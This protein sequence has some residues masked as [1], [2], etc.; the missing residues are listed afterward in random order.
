MVVSA[1]AGA[2]GSLA[3]QIAKIQGAASSASAAP[4]TRSAGCW[5]TSASTAPSTTAP[6]T[7]A[8]GSVS[9]ALI[10]STSTSTTWAAP[11]S[12]RCS[13]A[14]RCARRPLRRHR[15]LQRAGRPPGPSNY[16]QLINRRARMEGF[17]SLD[18]W[19][20][21]GEVAATLGDG[22]P[23]ASSEY[24]TQVYEGLDS[25]VDAL[26]ALFTG[27]NIGKTV[28]RRR[29]PPGRPDGPGGGPGLRRRPGG[30]GGT[31]IGRAAHPRV[32]A[33]R[34]KSV[35]GPIGPPPQRAPPLGLRRS[36]P[37]GDTRRA[38][39]AP[40]RK[41]WPRV[42]RGPATPHQDV[43]GCDRKVRTCRSSPASWRAEHVSRRRP[44]AGRCSRGRR[45]PG[46]RR[47]PSHSG[48]S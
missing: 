14:W 12:M 20:R 7:C 41:I 33:P 4:T 30:G 22:R 34:A 29:R 44:G 27:D 26:N 17:L 37:S 35:S 16:F 10:G 2:T 5:T 24:R 23:R 43:R 48:E 47:R 39:S 25:A 28:I 38:R 46:R 32:E 8:P 42:A 13:T 18:H 36:G 9:S 31:G 21:F 45:R 19:D 40:C 3:A 6:T 15:H 11:S 1:A